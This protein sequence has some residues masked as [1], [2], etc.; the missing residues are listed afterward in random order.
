MHAHWGESVWR[1]G[2]LNEDFPDSAATKASPRVVGPSPQHSR[3]RLRKELKRLPQETTLGA[4]FDACHCARLRGT[5]R[6]DPSSDPFKNKSSSPKAINL[7]Y[8]L[9]SLLSLPKWLHTKA[10]GVRGGE[11]EKPERES[12]FFEPMSRYSFFYL[13]LIYCFYLVFSVANFHGFSSFWPF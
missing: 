6:R 13:F 11:R 9:P 1:K 5:E 4:H 2:P 8:D 3:L 10:A 7:R 12:S